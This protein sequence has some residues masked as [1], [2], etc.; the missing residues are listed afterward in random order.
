MS[1]DLSPAAALDRLL[2][3]NRRYVDGANLHAHQ[4]PARRAEL[5]GE[6]HPFG[7]VFGCA[8]SRVPAEVVFDQG[9]GDLF[10][11]RNAGHI[12]DPSVLGSIEF[13]V[14]VLG[15]PLTLVLGHTSCGAVG[16]TINAIDSHSTPS[17]YLRDV[18][19]RIAPAV[20][21]ARRDPD[22]GYDDVV[23][24]NV[25][26][27]VTAIR[28]KSAAVDR[29]IT[30]GRTAIVGAIY[31]LEAGTVTPVHTEGRVNGG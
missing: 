24:E 20:F 5:T 19:E 25:R 12:V 18:V 14:D 1:T 22:A 30:E 26:Q 21:E 7:M 16:A 17:G 4:D 3:G 6:Q 13:G 15:I 9:L 10:V 11:I 23:I 27:T 8:D 28:E 2:T 29:A 31:N